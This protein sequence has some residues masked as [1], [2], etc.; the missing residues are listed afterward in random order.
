MTRESED[1]KVESAKKEKLP[2]LPKRNRAF[3][4]GD[5]TGHGLLRLSA[6]YPPSSAEL[7][8][9]RVQ[10]GAARASS[11][12]KSGTRGS[13]ARRAREKKRR[14]ARGVA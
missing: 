10:A 5:G 3:E 11:G 14:A 4:L 7:A 1:K 12:P 6:V 9:A 2:R 13:K 8:R